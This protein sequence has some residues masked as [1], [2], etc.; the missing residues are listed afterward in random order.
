MLTGNGNFKQFFSIPKNTS[1]H[2]QSGVVDVSAH[3]NAWHNAGM[4][5][6]GPL[7]EVAMK[8]ESYKCNGN[9]AQ[10]SGSGSVTKN[11]LTIGGTSPGGGSGDNNNFTLTA[12]AS[13]AAGGDV[14]K[15]PNSSSYAPNTN[16]TLTAAAKPGWT[17]SGWSGSG[18][19]GT[20]ATVTVKMDADKTVTATFTP[21]SGNTT[22]FIKNGT[23]TS[24]SDWTLNK[25]QNSAGTF[26]VSGGAANITGITRPSGTDAA[27]HSLQL[28]QNGILLI[29]GQ[30]YRLTFDAKAASNRTIDLVMQMDDDPWT[31]YY[32]KE[33]ISL[34]ADWQTFTYD[35]EMTDPTDENGR[36]AF[37]F[38][39][40]TP[41]VNI[42]NV[43]LNFSTGTTDPPPVDPPLSVS[44]KNPSAAVK[45]GARATAM[46]NSA[47]N[48]TFTASNSG[49]TTLKLYT[50]KGDVVSTA[51][52]RTV[53]GRSYSHTFSPGKLPNGFYVVGLHGNGTVEQT[54]VVIP[55]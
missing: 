2:R 41:N 12:I 46:P 53:A 49:E 8:I 26:G 5:M 21:T 13:P 10:G 51:R 20:N 4:Y 1:S 28:V 43:K 24:T 11:I 45:T 39:G 7:Y 54:R 16:V 31:T 19:S 22:N 23:F 52:V 47:V 6:D 32:S 15:N 50:L 29:T 34:T 44:L 36:I 25:W 42:R 35:F 33:G 30:K 48:V 37:N 55:K 14:T 9:Q 27:N 40:A 3:F 18:T 17:F 38:G